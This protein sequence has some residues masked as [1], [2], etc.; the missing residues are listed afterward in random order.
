MVV[1]VWDE[2]GYSLLEGIALPCG[3]PLGG[4][5]Q[6]LGGVMNL[7]HFRVSLSENEN[8]SRSASRG[9]NCF[10]VWDLGFRVGPRR[11]GFNEFRVH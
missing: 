11:T 8:S 10:R 5:M 9:K 7:L 1:I 3:Q 2:M 6:A 4:F